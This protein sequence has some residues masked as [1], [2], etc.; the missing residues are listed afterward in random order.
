MEKVKET[1][2]EVARKLRP[3]K[4]SWVSLRETLCSE[5]FEDKRGWRRIE[6]LWGAINAP[7]CR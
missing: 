4:G 6:A 2:T 1:T 5:G 3:K 7:F